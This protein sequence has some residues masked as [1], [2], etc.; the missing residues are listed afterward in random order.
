MIG[1][2]FARIWNYIQM[3]LSGFKQKRR[4]VH[5]YLRYVTLFFTLANFVATF[6]R[7]L[8]GKWWHLMGPLVSLILEVYFCYFLYMF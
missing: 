3:Q 8:A 2:A 7:V 5:L 6:F 4:Y 1:L